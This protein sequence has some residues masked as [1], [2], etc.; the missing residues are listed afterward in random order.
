V[1]YII[2]F[3]YRWYFDITFL[4]SICLHSQLGINTQRQSIPNYLKGC[5]LVGGIFIASYIS[6]VH[7]KPSQLFTLQLKKRDLSVD[8]PPHQWITDYQQKSNC[9]IDWSIRT[10]HCIPPKFQQTSLPR[11]KITAEMHISCYRDTELAILKYF[12]QILTKF[13][14]VTCFRC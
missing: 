8:E 13:Y 10:S 4:H 12:N 7:Y 9:S 3:G 2:S 5:M 14:Y 1:T 6:H 11:S